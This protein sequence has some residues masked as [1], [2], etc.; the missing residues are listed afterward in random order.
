MLKSESLIL[1]FVIGFVQI[2]IGNSL[3]S[4]DKDLLGGDNRV[5]AEVEEIADIR[6]SS[7]DISLIKP[8]NEDGSSY[9]NDFGS[10]WVWPEFTLDLVESYAPF[11]FRTEISAQLEE[12][13]VVLN[14][15]NKGKLIGYEFITEVDKGLEERMGYVL[16]KLPKCLPVPGYSDYGAADFELI[17]KR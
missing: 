3:D 17:I 14:V 2:G 16:R 7:S 15:N 8:I 10:A 1:F 9:P 13:R 4:N 6:M 12:V 11:L 5:R